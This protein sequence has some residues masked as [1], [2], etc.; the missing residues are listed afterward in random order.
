MNA[1][2]ISGLNIPVDNLSTLIS[3]HS[4]IEAKVIDTNK[5]C[6]VLKNMMNEL[7]QAAV[8]PVKATVQSSAVTTSPASSVTS[9]EEISDGDVTVIHTPSTSEPQGNASDMELSRVF[10]D[11]LASA[12]EGK[13]DLT[14]EIMKQLHQINVRIDELNTVANNLQAKWCELDNTLQLIINEIENLK[15]Y[16]KK[17]SLLLHNFP[18]PPANISSLQYSMFVTEQLNKFLPHLPITLKWEHISTAHYL[19]TKAKKSEVI[20]VRF[21]NRCV[22]DMIFEHRHLLPSPFGITEHLTDRSQTIMRK[23]RDLFGYDYVHTR[24]CKVIVHLYGRDHT[25]SSIT[26]VHKLFAWYCQFIGMNNDT[27]LATPRSISRP[28]HNAASPARTS[29]SYAGAVKQPP[30]NT[31]H[32]QSFYRSR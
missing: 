32:S 2:D 16:T 29:T 5:E 1:A 6:R 12:A 26:S 25:V 4:S 27:P 17:E 7:L 20:I 31:V 18:L 10:N 8:S 11:F 19:P 14:D 30:M 3:E 24:D 28:R 15:Q 13:L 9:I 22:K 23:A 21:A